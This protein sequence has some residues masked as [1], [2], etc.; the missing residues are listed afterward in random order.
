MPSA[1]PIVTSIFTFGLN[2]SNYRWRN[3]HT[4]QHF[5]EK[6]FRRMEIELLVRH[7]RGALLQR[8]SQDY[9]AFSHYGER[10]QEVPVC[11]SRYA[12]CQTIS[13]TLF[14][15]GIFPEILAAHRSGVGI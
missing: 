12:E 3:V 1:P 10:H 2:S 8:C 13:R 5:T 14:V 11:F 7:S 15:G 9:S 6:G 4:R